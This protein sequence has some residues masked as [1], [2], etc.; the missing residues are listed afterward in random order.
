MKQLLQ[1][2]EGRGDDR[3]GLRKTEVRGSIESITQQITAVINKSKKTTALD[4]EKTA[5]SMASEM[6]AMQ[7]NNQR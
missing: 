3:E 2:I 6:Q 7:E 4:T 5:V 1:S